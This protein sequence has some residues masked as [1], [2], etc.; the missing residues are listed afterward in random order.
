MTICQSYHV[1]HLQEINRYTKSSSIEQKVLFM[2]LIKCYWH[3]SIVCVCLLWT[4]HYHLAIYNNSKD[5]IKREI[6]KDVYC[7]ES[8]LNPHL[9]IEIDQIY[10]CDSKRLMHFFFSEFFWSPRRGVSIKES[11]IKKQRSGSIKT[12]TI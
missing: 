1:N 7:L 4:I 11:L 8:T 9:R 5:T 10:N 2:D 3:M 6:V 12:V